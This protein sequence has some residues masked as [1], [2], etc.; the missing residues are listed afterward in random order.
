MVLVKCW[1]LAVNKLLACLAGWLVAFAVI[2]DA[3]PDDHAAQLWQR[4]QA[5]DSLSA[6]FTQIVKGA[7]GVVVQEGSGELSVR[8]PGLMHW[9]ATEPYKEEVVIDGERIWFY[10]R[11]L[12]QVTVRR[13]EED[14]R[15]LPALVFTSDQEALSAAFAVSKTGVDSFELVPHDASHYV[16]KLS[17]RWEKGLP[18]ELVILDNLNN[19][20][21]L[22]LSAA[23][24]NTITDNRRFTFTPPV[25]VDV[26]DQTG[27]RSP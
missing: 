25:G 20:T 3:T 26:I 22:R 4:L 7:D 18:V 10:D 27:Q 24:I 13:F 23:R 21:W 16:R 2:A 9:L 1:W 11:D 14:L 8:K 5:M 19:Q 12:E 6:Q 15:Q 17:L